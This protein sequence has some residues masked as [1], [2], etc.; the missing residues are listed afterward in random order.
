MARSV[1]WIRRI[2]RYQRELLFGAPPDVD[3]I[4]LLHR[5]IGREEFHEL[6]SELRLIRPTDGEGHVMAAR[7]NMIGFCH[8]SSRAELNPP[9]ELLAVLG[10]RQ[11]DD[12][13]WEAEEA[14]EFDVR[15]GDR[16]GAENDPSSKL[17]H[18]YSLFLEI[19]SWHSCLQ[20][21]DLVN[22]LLTLV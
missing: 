9:S 11:G 19:G 15:S 1:T 17:G 10:E 21:N 20:C 7:V 8:A 12:V 16:R 13:L 2:V 3:T 5:P 6:V 14:G 4:L 18:K 22:A